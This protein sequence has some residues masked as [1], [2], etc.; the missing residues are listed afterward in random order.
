ML[1]DGNELDWEIVDGKGLKIK[2]PNTK[3]CEHAYVFKIVRE[4]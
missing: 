4:Y 1:G 2:T 3:P